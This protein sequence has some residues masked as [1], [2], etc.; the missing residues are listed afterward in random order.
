MPLQGDLVIFAEG[1]T[2][3]GARDALKTMNP[4]LPRRALSTDVEHMYLAPWGQE[5]RT[6][7]SKRPENANSQNLAWIALLPDSQRL[8][9]EAISGRLVSIP[10]H[11][12]CEKK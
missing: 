7:C 5:V 8:V 9:E 11:G 10:D 4:F 3:D 6:A 12:R 1:S 2:E